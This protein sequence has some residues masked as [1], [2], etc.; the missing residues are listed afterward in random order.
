MP[1]LLVVAPALARRLDHTN[2][3]W[4]AWTRSKRLSAALLAPAFLAILVTAPDLVPVVFGAK[5]R[6]AIPVLQLLCCAGVAHALVTLN[7]SVLQ[8]RGR[9]GT[10]LWLNLL[11]S[12]VTVSAFAVGLRW[13]VA[14]VAGSYAIAKWLLVLPDTWITCR[15]IGARTPETLRSS[16]TAIPSAMAAAAVA[17]G[18][19]VA[20]VGAGAPPALRLALVL[21]SGLAAYA[22]L[23]ALLA[24]ALLEEVRQ[25]VRERRAAVLP[26]AV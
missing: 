26:S 15:A 9:A 17:F 7:W 4:T 19:R 3:L 24:P 6:H 2:R 5:W 11:V 14:G 20:L 13:G 1:S 16:A 10:L 25:L 8:A 12:A 22:A 18:T 23:V 21:A